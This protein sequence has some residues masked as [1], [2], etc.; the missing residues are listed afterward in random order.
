[1]KNLLVLVCLTITMIVS[2]QKGYVQT[3]P[4]DTVNG[5]ETLYFETPEI[6]KGGSVSYGILCEN[7]GGTSDGTISLEG[8]VDGD[9]FFSL[10]DSIDLIYKFIS[11]TTTITDNAVFGY[12]I[13]DNPFSKL[14]VKIVG[15]ANDSTLI[16]PSYIA[17]N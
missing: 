17:K 4:S 11:D 14:R 7:V 12:V 1:M 16:Y 5:A 15:T 13:K 6:L 10:P 9:N 3:I 2:A 8:S